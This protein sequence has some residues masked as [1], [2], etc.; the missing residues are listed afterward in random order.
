MAMV[1]RTIETDIPTIVTGDNVRL[2]KTRPDVEVRRR[3]NDYRHLYA[4]AFVARRVSFINV[5]IN[6]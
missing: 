2:E 5:L 4:G 3:D 6:N 1:Y